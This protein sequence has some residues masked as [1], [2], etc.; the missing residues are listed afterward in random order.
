MSI[1]NSQQNENNIKYRIFIEENGELH[2]TI[3]F[4]EAAAMVGKTVR[5]L[6]MKVKAGEAPKVH[7]ISNRAYFREDEF[8]SWL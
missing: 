5:W 3:P 1:T 6:Q 4:A 7:K 8:K 2:P